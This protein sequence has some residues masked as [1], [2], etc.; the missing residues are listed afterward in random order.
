M[1]ANGN[2]APLLPILYVAANLAFNICSLLVV[3]T[4]GGCCVVLCGCCVVHCAGLS[5]AVQ[6]VMRS[7]VTRSRRANHW[8]LSAAPACPCCFGKRAPPSRDYHAV[9]PSAF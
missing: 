6:A 3:R 8:D 7:D 9:R 1:G 4:S 2:G 5:S